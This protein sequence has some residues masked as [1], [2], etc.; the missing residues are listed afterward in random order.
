MF[1]IALAVAA[2]AISAGGATASDYQL[3]VEL[4][5]IERQ[6]AFVNTMFKVNNTGADDYRTVFVECTFFDKNK[7]ALDSSMRSLENVSSGSTSY[8]KVTLL[9]KLN[10]IKF[11]ECRAV[12]AAKS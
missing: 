12:N 4:Q 8:G 3:S 2:L 9:R 5:N 1:R 6:G 10:D 11:A 7:R